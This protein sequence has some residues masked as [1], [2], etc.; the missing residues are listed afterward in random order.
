[1]G[2]GASTG[3]GQRAPAPAN[4]GTACSASLRSGYSLQFFPDLAC[5]TGIDAQQQGPFLPQATMN[6][7]PDTYDGPL[8]RCVITQQALFGYEYRYRFVLERV[9]LDSG[10]YKTSHG[11]VFQGSIADPAPGVAKTPCGYVFALNVV[12]ERT[13]VITAKAGDEVTMA[14]QLTPLAN[15]EYLAAWTILAKDGRLLYAA[16]DNPTGVPVD[17]SLL[18][19][20]QLSLRA[21]D[22]CLAPTGPV[23]ASVGVGAAGEATCLFDLQTG[24]CCSLWKHDYLAYLF[25]SARPEGAFLGSYA[26][27]VMDRD[28]L[29]Y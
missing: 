28:F 13:P 9:V 10:P 25:S 21:T 20:L 16:I 17:K 22:Y 5:P 14:G 27:Q 11:F 3:G 26:V 12:T 24:G 6:Q 7:Y 23:G 4:M 19:G 29:S 2:G 8:P 18:G 1:V 15:D